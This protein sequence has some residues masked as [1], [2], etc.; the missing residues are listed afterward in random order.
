MKCPK[1][2]GNAR[3][4]GR[5]DFAPWYSKYPAYYH[6]FHC[7]HSLVKDSLFKKTRALGYEPHD[8]KLFN[9]ILH[10]LNKG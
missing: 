2:G 3:F 9:A 4:I 6:C 10:D 7:Q 1:C 8:E 5:S